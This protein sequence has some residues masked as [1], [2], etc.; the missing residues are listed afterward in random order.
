MEE[1][2]RKRTVVAQRLKKREVILERVVKCSLQG[3]LLEKSLMPEI[4]RWVLTNSK[5]TNK[6][7]LVFN[8][9]LLHCLNRGLPLPDLTDQTLYLQCFN[10]GDGKLNK[11]NDVL[12]EVWD[13]CFQRFP[14]TEKCRGDTQAYVYAYK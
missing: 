7:A 14:A 6:G 2:E 1:K 10:I 11:A 12:K 3:R 9:L 4:Q 5:I 13:R 8:R